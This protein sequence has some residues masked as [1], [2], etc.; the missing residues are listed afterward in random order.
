MH[1]ARHVVLPP[2]RKSARNY[3]HAEIVL[4]PHPP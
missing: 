2:P 1:N 3:S 4:T